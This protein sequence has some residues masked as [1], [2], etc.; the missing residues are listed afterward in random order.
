MID[1]NVR[2]EPDTLRNLVLEFR[3][4]GARFFFSPIPGSASR[5]F[6]SLM[7][8]TGLNYFTSG[9]VIS[10]WK[11]FSRPIVVGKLML[12]EREVLNSLG[13][14][15]KFKDYLAENYLIGKSF[16]NGGSRVST[17]FT[18]ATNINQQA[19]IRSFYR[20]MIRWARLRY[21]LHRPVYLAEI[22]LNPMVLA[23]AGLLVIG[24]NFWWL[25]PLTV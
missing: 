23:V 13:S 9:N 14:F 20:R 7:E 21:Q 15:K 17:D 16:E 4:S 10:L 5:T 8:N 6:A 3:V 11:I 22:L 12:I 25:V 19:T 1:A 24:A 2:V 18:W